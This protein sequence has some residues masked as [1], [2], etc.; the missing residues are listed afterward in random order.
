M[1][2]LFQQNWWVLLLCAGFAGFAGWVLHWRLSAPRLRDLERERDRMRTEFEATVT[3]FR[4][5]LRP[6]GD[7]REQ[8][9]FRTRESIAAAKVAELDRTLAEVREQRDAHAG[10]T[11]ELER[12]LERASFEAAAAQRRADAAE[13]LARTRGEPNT[14]EMNALR[15]R[16]RYFEARTRYLEDASGSKSTD[17]ASMIANLRAERDAA[18][19]EAEHL[20][21]RQPAQA[22]TGTDE[23]EALKW[24]ARYLEARVRRLESEAAATDEESA[25]RRAWR[26]RY[27]ETRLQHLARSVPKA[28]DK[29]ARR[30]KWRA[31]YLDARVRH[32]E[33]RLAAAPIPESAPGEAPGVIETPAGAE[34]RP[35][36]LAAPREGAPDDLMLIDGMSPKTA[37][38]LN[39]LGI[40]HFEQIANWSAANVAWVDQYLRLRGR[41]EREQWV[42]QA[43][44][45]A[46]GGAATRR[47][48]L[49]IETA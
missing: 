31:R 1:W 33:Q 34:V 26:T 49:E 10:R 23:G 29:E 3:G 4:Q 39:A 22:T 37:S 16:L 30:L 41:I 36:A 6:V 15:W 48:Y 28:D 44:A 18:R 12:A 40:Y 35:Q 2:F 47:L 17:D 42:E 32:L 43:R 8:A 20:R 46:R 13:T 21:E 11:A 38:A 9:F 45:L 14:D 24:R 25:N 19:L 5:G 27:L 7:D